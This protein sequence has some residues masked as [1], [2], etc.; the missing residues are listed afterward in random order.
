MLRE[1]AQLFRSTKLAF[2]NSKRSVWI[3]QNGRGSVEV[4]QM[5]RLYCQKKHGTQKGRVRVSRQRWNL[6]TAPPFMGEQD[7]LLLPCALLLPWICGRR[8]AWSCDFPARGLSFTR[9]WR[10]GI[11]WKAQRKKEGWDQIKIKKLV[12]LLLGCLAG[13]SGAGAA[14]AAGF[15]FFA[16]LA[17]RACLKAL[18]GDP[19][20]SGTV[21]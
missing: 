1:R 12:Y 11:W 4:G 20:C 16:C 2:V 15:S 19:G 9:C 7:L 14:H 8:S 13:R 5:I 21:S 6:I 3:K 17:A 10:S 18:L